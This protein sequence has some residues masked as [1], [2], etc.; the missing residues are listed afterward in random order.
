MGRFGL[1]I[2]QYEI[3]LVNLNPILGTEINKVRHCLVISPDELNEPLKTVIVAPLTT[4][5]RENYPFR[6]ISNIDDKKGQIALDQIRMIDKRRCIKRVCEIDEKTKLEVKEI[7][8]KML[9]E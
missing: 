3:Y 7:I 1:K 2:K 4:K 6:P 8:S 9:V 5:I